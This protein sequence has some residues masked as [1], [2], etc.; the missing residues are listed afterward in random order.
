M[1]RTASLVTIL[2]VVAASCGFLPAPPSTPAVEPLILNISNGTTLPVTLRVNG[3]NVGPFLPGTGEAPIRPGS[4]PNP[5]WHVEALTPS[6]RVLLAFDVAPGDVWHTTP[7]PQGHSSSQGAGARAD[8][9]C[10]R[11]DV[12]SGPPM[13]GP[14]TWPGMSFPPHDCDP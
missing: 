4:L 8:L 5:P 1:V 6:G 11:L 13:L 7:D 14:G 9:S 10:G 12:W 3:L 2:C